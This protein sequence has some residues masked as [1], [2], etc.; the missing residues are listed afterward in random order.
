[1]QGLDFPYGVIAI[2]LGIGFMVAKLDAQ[3][4][5]ASDFA[6]VPPQDFERWRDWTTSIYRL[7][8]GACFLRVIFQQ[9][10]AYYVSR[11]AL[12]TPAWPASL[13]YPA[14]LV[15]V[16][17]LGLVAVTFVRA[18]R[19]RAL[20]RELNIVLSPMTPQQQA[21]TSNTDEGEDAAKDEAR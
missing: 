3:G 12:T 15:D 1:V 6:H 8:A 21:A 4:R 19:A 14:L 17:W 18:G 5:K 9:G 2:V 16:L 20:R 11:Q 13:R 10:W 7:G